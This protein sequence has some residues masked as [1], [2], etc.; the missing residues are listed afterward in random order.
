MGITTFPPQSGGDPTLSNLF[1][2]FG[3]FPFAGSTDVTISSNTTWND[4]SGYRKV[5]KLTITAGITLRINLTPFFIFA[6]EIVFGDANSTIDI[7][8]PN[9]AASGNF[10]DI[11]A[12]GATTTDTTGSR[13]Q[14]GC[15]GG[16]IFIVA[17]KISGAAGKIKA[18]GGTG[19]VNQTMAVNAV[20]QVHGYGAFGIQAYAAPPFLLG[21]VDIS[22]SGIV[23]FPRTSNKLLGAGSGGGNYGSGGF[24]VGGGGVAKGAAGYTASDVGGTWSLKP[25]PE[26]LLS[27]AKMGL[28]GGGGGGAVVAG[29]GNYNTAGGGGGGSVVVWVRDLDVTP[30][31]TVNGGIGAWGSSITTNTQ[32]IK[33]G[34][35]ATHIVVV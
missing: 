30:T 23:A 14:G 4:A 19:Y 16:M 5:K 8:G 21:G 12:M 32:Y 25:T 24:G 10:E 2:Q 9:G 18:D 26:E 1:G 31:I 33:G 35:G 34:A 15:G 13:A 7:S 22:T 6:D 3:K 29:G 20:P 11:F 27:F 28:R 17:R